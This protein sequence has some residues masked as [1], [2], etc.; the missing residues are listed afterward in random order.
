[1]NSAHTQHDG[2]GSITPPSPT[3]PA[4]QQA[5][6]APT[7][8]AGRRYQPRVDLIESDDEWL[9]VADVPG[10]TSDGIDVR[11]EDGLLTLQARVAA[12]S[13]GGPKFARREYG[14]GDFVRSVRFGDAVDPDGIVAEYDRGELVVHLPKAASLKPRTIQ[15][16]AG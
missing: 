16:R 8:A 4:D 10:A 7:V 13:F 2:T 1:M 3:A 15:V 11:F 12:R 6:T 9:L 5:C 14:V